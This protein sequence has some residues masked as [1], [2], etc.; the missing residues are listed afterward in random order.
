MADDHKDALE[1]HK[2]CSDAAQE[3]ERTFEDDM[4]FWRMDEQWSDATKAARSV[5]GQERP[6]FTFNRGPTFARQVINDIRQNRPQIKVR[7]ADSGAD[8]ET[9]LVQ[10]GLIRNIN[11]A[12][13][14]DVARDT[15][16]ECAV[17]GGFGYYRI[18]I[19][20][21]CD[22][23]FDKDIRI[24]RIVNPL[25]VKGDPY[26]TRADSLDWNMAFYIDLMTPDAFKE[27]YPKADP[28]SFDM[29][30]DKVRRDWTDGRDIVVAEYWK[31]RKVTKTL[32]RTT[33][34][35]AYDKERFFEKDPE[36]GLS[37]ADMILV[38]GVGVNGERPYESYLVEQ[39]I[40]NGQ[41]TLTDKVTW[42][43]KYIPIIPIYGEEMYFKGKR[44]LW[45]ML[46][47]ARHAQE[48]FNYH[49]TTATELYALSPRIPFI[50][51]KGFADSD[52]RWETANSQNHPFLEYDGQT[53]P[54]R[55][56]LDAGP[57]IGAMSLSKSAGDNLKAVL[58]MY[59][60][61]LGQKSNESSGIAI[62]R[63]DRQSDVGNFHF[64]DNVSRAIECEGTML[65][66]LIPKVYTHNRIVRVLGEDGTTQDVRLGKRDP[67]AMPAQRDPNAEPPKIGKLAGVYDLTAGKYDLTV[68]AG[69]S[70]TTM[71]QETAAVVGELMRAHP[72]MMP[73]GGDILVANLDLKDGEELARRM[74]KMLPPQLQDE[75]EQQIPPQ[76]MQQMDQMKEAIQVLTEENQKLQQDQAGKMAQA[77]KAKT[78][79][80]QKQ[81]VN[82]QL[83][84]EEKKIPVE[85]L[86]A[87]LNILTAQKELMAAQANL[88]KVRAEAAMIQQQT[89][90]EIE[91]GQ[92]EQV[93]AAVPA[94]MQAIE[95]VRIEATRPKRKQGRAQ[96]VNGQWQFETVEAPEAPA[97]AM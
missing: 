74:K 89:K 57:M 29:M 10:Q 62:E 15:A 21:A 91:T 31:R 97:G 28:V 88:E 18:D 77:E 38:E 44:V 67:G 25:C 83:D 53:P 72:D 95:S 94:I 12:S 68:E 32:I 64:T 87:Q 26:S 86:E 63:R 70:Y 66:D 37:Q 16:A 61:S 11:V 3:N 73:I 46:H 81:V 8:I 30:D 1:A 96:K 42:A 92:N 76:V 20:Y 35:H 17:Y 65:L 93:N 47:R 90:T 9:A 60:A 80:M 56:P 78:E 84:I 45:S 33:D 82:R 23:S 40:L 41:E 49:E 43:G 85:Q 4:R 27:E 24:N 6:M 48:Q 75:G 19:E 34:G 13:K 2:V 36:T 39:C 55:Q 5:P 54:T 58:G 71:R 50:G 22:D 59:D 51:P 69:P 7:P 79:Q 52:S 14:G